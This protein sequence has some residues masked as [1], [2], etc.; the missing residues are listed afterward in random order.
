MSFFNPQQEKSLNAF[1]IALSQQDESLPEGLQKQL[2]AIGQNLE[3]RVVEI[4]VI[5][6]SI[7][8]LDRAYRAALADNQEDE[9]VATPISTNQDQSTKFRERAVQILTDSDSVR[10]AQKKVHRGRVQTASNPLKRL[11]NLG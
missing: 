4:P 5:A 2:H 10:A 9:Q 3:N 6:A 7:P 1:L 8:S 11:F